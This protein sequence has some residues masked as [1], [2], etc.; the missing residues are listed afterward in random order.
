[1]GGLSG[2]RRVQPA[3]ELLDI[4]EEPTEWCCPKCGALYSAEDQREIVEIQPYSCWP[5]VVEDM[6]VRMFPEGHDADE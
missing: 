4:P 3:D 1:M 2:V 6:D 5:E